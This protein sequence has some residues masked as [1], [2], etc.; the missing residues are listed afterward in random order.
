MTVINVYAQFPTAFDDNDKPSLDPA[1]WQWTHY[2]TFPLAQ[3]EPLGFLHKPYKWLRF[4]TGITLGSI[5]SFSVDPSVSDPKFDYERGLP[6]ESEDLYYHT[7]IPEK[8]HMFPIDPLMLSLTGRTTSSAASTRRITF[9]EEIQARDGRQCVV[10]GAPARYCDA[11]HLVPHARG[12]AVRDTPA[13]L[14]SCSL[15][16]SSTFKRSRAGVSVM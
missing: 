11:V 1:N 6:S 14:S 5:G 13:T 8:E 9:V 15:L 7:T 10:S 4:C 12:S 3:L 2:L 16:A